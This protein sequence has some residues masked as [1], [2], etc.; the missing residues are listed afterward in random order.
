MYMQT[1]VSPLPRL[2][3]AYHESRTLGSSPW[4]LNFRTETGG[5]N[6][7]QLSDDF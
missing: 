7:R 6:V 5:E 4:G 1:I 2:N 3:Q